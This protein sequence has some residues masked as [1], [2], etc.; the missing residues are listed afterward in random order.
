MRPVLRSYRSAD[1]DNACAVELPLLTIADVSVA[2]TSNKMQDWQNM[3]VLS[4]LLD[5]GVKLTK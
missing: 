1:Q 4:I 2:F 3:Y 5:E